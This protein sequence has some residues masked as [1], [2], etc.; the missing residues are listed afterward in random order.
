MERR[1]AG[2]LQ[3]IKATETVDR[4]QLNGQSLIDPSSSMLLMLL[5]SY[6]IDVA[7]IDNVASGLSIVQRASLFIASDI[8]LTPYRRVLAAA[9]D[10][11]TPVYTLRPA[12]TMSMD[13]LYELIKRE[14]FT[15]VRY[16]TSKFPALQNTV[17]KLAQEDPTFSH[18]IGRSEF[19]KSD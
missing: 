9:R 11:Q 4:A 2:L 13:K 12:D 17:Q 8:N 6:G 14:T 10:Y 18:A 16:N 15:R 1:L 19:L 7:S 3:P 5:E